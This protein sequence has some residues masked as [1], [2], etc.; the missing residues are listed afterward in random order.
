MASGSP[1]ARNKLETAEKY[2]VKAH[3]KV[4]AGVFLTLALYSDIRPTDNKKLSS[5]GLPVGPLLKPP[6]IGLNTDSTKLAKLNNATITSVVG[7]KE[8]GS[9]K[10]ST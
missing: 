6:K 1:S 7:V 5:P 10:H 2:Y 4:K 9:I 8:T 3:G